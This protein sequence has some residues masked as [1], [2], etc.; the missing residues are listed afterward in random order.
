VSELLRVEKLN[1]H[2]DGIYAL[3]DAHCAVAPG[4]V[5]ALMGENG[6]GKSTLAK[7]IA[8][9]VKAD[10]GVIFMDGLPVS[11]L[12][13]V[14]AQRHGIAVIYQEL[15]L[16]P[17]LTVAENIVI[18]TLR[19]ESR[20]F[21]DFKELDRFCQPLLDQVGLDCSPRAL[22]A[23]LSIGQMQLVAIAR[24]LS[25]QARLILMDEPTSSLFGDSV[26]TLFRLIA[27]LKK[28]GVSIIYVSHKMDEIFR[29]C[30]RVTVLRDGATIATRAIADTTVNELI[31]MMV[32]RD[33]EPRSHARDVPRGDVILSVAGLTTG[34]LRDISFDLRQGEVLGVAGLVG[35]GRSELGAALFG[36]D[37]KTSGTVSLSG[38]PVAPESARKAIDLGIGLLPEDRKRQG[39]MMQMTV[40]ENSTMAILG[41]L[42]RFGFLSVKQE[43]DA[44]EPL[45]KELALKAPSGDTCVSALSGGN[46]Q[47]ILLAKC[48]LAGPDLLFLDDPTRGIDVGAKQ[49]I[50]R[51]IEKLAS[52][53]KGV[54]FVSSEL[55]E[56]LRCCDRIMV[57][58]EGRITAVLDA[59]EATQEKI[60][61]AAAVAG[62]CV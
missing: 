45:F 12:S 13:P 61:A 20:A 23:S 3:K 30:D 44:V 6:A 5:H 38:K 37:R 2:Y 62:A 11:I 46:Q 49:D 14:D 42:E 54:I 53:G 7:I 4:E 8:G 31:R 22:V 18:G 50:Y 26:E 48:L 1:K 24:A 47:K 40:F 60:M 15:D 28:R 56:L 36:M 29:I 34:K 10:S 52:S 19:F 41:R 9:S 25:M 57:M 16:F 35:A 55:P 27:D 51:I 58:R 21:V 17:R 43:A 32:G 39:L 59:A 33:I